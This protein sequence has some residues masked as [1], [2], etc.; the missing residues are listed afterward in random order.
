MRWASLL[1]AL[2]M[3]S[4]AVTACAIGGGD[5]DRNVA[6]GPGTS[7]AATGSATGGS[8]SNT[9]ASGGSTTVAG[10]SQNTGG[11]STGGNSAGGSA[12]GGIGTGAGGGTGGTGLL[13]P[14]LG[15]PDPSGAPCM[16]YGFGSDCPGIAVC[17]MSGPNM[18]TCESCT[19][20][21]NLN[22]P[23]TQSSDCDILFQCYQGSCTN[24]CPLGTTYCGPVADCLDIGHTTH[25]VC[26]P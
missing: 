5:S 21:N 16:N 2:G 23:C 3:G 26:R 18:G 8:S 22:Q 1:G 19:T 11:N 25:G 24:I 20:C 4:I 7:A 12:T 10:G 6:T 13:D 9:T 15:L 14:D 17:R